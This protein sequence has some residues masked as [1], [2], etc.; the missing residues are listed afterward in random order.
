MSGNVTVSGNGSSPVILID[1]LAFGPGVGLFLSLS[2]GAVLTAT[3]Q[4]TG[5]P[6]PLSHNPSLG[7]WINHD[8]LVNLTASQIGSLSVPATGARLVVSGWTSGSATL[9]TVQAA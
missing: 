3:V 8:T 9:T 2:A 5:D 6:T 7:N 4:L 1:L